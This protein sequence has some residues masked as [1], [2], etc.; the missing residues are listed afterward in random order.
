MRSIAYFSSYSLGL[1]LFVVL[2]RHLL[3]GLRARNLHTLVL[4]FAYVAGMFFAAHSLFFL[5]VQR[6]LR[7]P[8]A[9]DL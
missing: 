6:S 3:A 2:V 1:V 5:V 8:A 9:A 7:N 4:G